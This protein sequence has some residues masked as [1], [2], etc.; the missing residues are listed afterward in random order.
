MFY[1][2]TGPD[3]NIYYKLLVH[4]SENFNR[5]LKCKFLSVLCICSSGLMASF[6]YDNQH[7]VTFLLESTFHTSC[8]CT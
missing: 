7:M 4:Y 3:L 2:S 1:T 6:D 5:H 8:I